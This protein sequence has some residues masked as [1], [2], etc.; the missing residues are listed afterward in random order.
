MDQTFTYIFTRIAPYYPEGEARALARLVLETRFGFTWAEICMGKD[1]PLL[2]EQRRELENIVERLQ[3]KEPV[4]YILGEAEFC[5]RRFEVAP[6][7][8]VP[9]PETEELVDWVIDDCKAHGVEDMHVLDIGTGSGCIAVTLACAFPHARV[10]AMDV[11]AD[12][13]QIARRNA[14]AA[15]RDIAFLQ[16]DILV[17]AGGLDVAWDVIVSNPPYVCECEKRGMDTNVLAYEPAE[18]L[19]VPDDD[20]LRFYRAIGKYAARTLA[21]GGK[22]YVEINRAFG[23][24]TSV[25][26]ESLGLRRVTLKKDAYGNNRM[27]RCEK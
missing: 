21:D 20:P 24:E 15:G 16:K 26:F 17:E 13:L 6:G 8:L 22:L 11:S 25:L 9:R 4:Q 19:F 18:A 27:I 3:R 5:G 2:L 23:E 1:A 14:L 7:V 10:S 12:A